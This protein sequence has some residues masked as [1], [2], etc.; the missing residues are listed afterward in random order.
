[1]RKYGKL[2]IACV[3]LGLTMIMIVGATF[4]WLAENRTAQADGMQFK[5]ETVSNLLISNSNAAENNP[6]DFEAEATIGLTTLSPAS[7]QTAAN[8]SAFFSISSTARATNVHY[9]TG[10]LK[11][12]D[13]TG[14]YIA[15][16]PTSASTYVLTSDTSIVTDK[17]YYTRS[18]SDPNY[19]YTAVAEPAVANIGTYYEERNSGYVAK[20][21]F[22][23]K[24]EEANTLANLYVNAITVTGTPTPD[25]KIY[26][27]LRVAVVCGANAFIY[28]P[29]DGATASYKGLIADNDNV[30]AVSS[31][32]VDIAT[33]PVSPA[34]ASD[35]DVLLQSVS[36]SWTAITIYVWI[37]GQDLACKNANIDVSVIEVSVKL[38]AFP[39]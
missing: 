22:Y 35:V 21:T 1:M 18:G 26:S 30:A 5:V 39:A 3:W 6:G 11:D 38:S 36:T 20:H 28:E 7:T 15:V 23:V 8:D 29:V 17:V 13:A 32:N 9:D 33:I 34:S 2:I 24:T 31:E 37:E 25:A 27:A 16:T 4:A 10:V 12:D 19:T 14:T